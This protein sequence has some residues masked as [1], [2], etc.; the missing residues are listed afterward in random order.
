MPYNPIEGLVISYNWFAAGHAWVSSALSSDE[1][2]TFD[3]KRV[4]G[5]RR[6]VD[7]GVKHHHGI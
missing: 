1:D 6:F 5:L 3:P 4:W 2:I 7:A